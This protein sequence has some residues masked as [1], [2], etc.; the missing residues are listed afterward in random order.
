MTTSGTETPSLDEV[1]DY[2]RPVLAHVSRRGYAWSLTLNEWPDDIRAWF[3]E[4]VISPKR[5]LSR[6]VA[7]FLFHFGRQFDL[8][9]LEITP[10]DERRDVSVTLPF[11]IALDWFGGLESEGTLTR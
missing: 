10:F 6:D 1:S 2:S 5:M 9:R 3:A 8:G 7:A 11:H 4:R